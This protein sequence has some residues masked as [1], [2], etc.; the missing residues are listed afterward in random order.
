LASNL[1]GGIYNDGGALT[2]N[3]MLVVANI[4]NNIYP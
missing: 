4:P 1:G 3:S 2:L